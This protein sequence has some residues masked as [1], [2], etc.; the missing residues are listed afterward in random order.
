MTPR[1]VRRAPEVREDRI[2]GTVSDPR[3]ERTIELIA[4]VSH[5]IRSPLTTIKGFTKTLLDRW[6]RLS[7]EIKLEMLARDQRRRRSR[8]AHPHRAAR[9]LPARSRQAHAPLVPSSSV[10]SRRKSWT[11]LERTERPVTRS[12]SQTAMP[13]RCIADRDKLR[14]VL[15]NFIENAQKYTDSGTITS[16]CCRADDGWAIVEVTD[17][18][19]V[20]PRRW[21]SEIFEK[22]AGASFR[23]RRPGRPRPVHL[24]GP[25][26]GARRRDRCC[27]SRA[28]ARRS[29]SV[30]RVAERAMSD[31]QRRARRELR[32]RG[33]GGDRA[34]PDPRLSSTRSTSGSSDARV[35]PQRRSFA[36][37]G[38]F[39]TPTR[40]SSARQAT[41]SAGSRGA[42]SPRSAR[43]S[44]GRTK[45]GS[46]RRTAST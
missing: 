29:G 44:S 34:A 32:E 41:G 7:D 1:S 27:G 13:S 37:S 4:T 3:E 16:S 38:T 18:G 17:E 21:S 24:Q 35:A 23:A 12:S 28:A 2:V 36:A 22:F 25:D 31:L 39:P 15:T 19:R 9:R 10:S 6:D 43:S 14:Q 8:H 30:F 20:S 42:R 40:R 5:E 11:T 46:S 45:S 26:R 33:R